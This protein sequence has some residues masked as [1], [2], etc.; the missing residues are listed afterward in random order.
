MRWRSL[1]FPFVLLAA[2]SSVR[3]AE[4]PE[5][6]RVGGIEAYFSGEFD[7]AV[8]HLKH[9][10]S[11]APEAAERASRPDE[12]AAYFLGRSFQELGLRGLALHYLGRAEGAAEW[13]LPALR[14]IARLYLQVAEYPAV[15]EVFARLR[16]GDRDGEI[17][18]LAGIAAAAQG[19]WVEAADI[20]GR[21]GSRDPYH[22]LALY[23]RARARAAA[24]DFTAA[25]GDLDGVA[26]IGAAAPQGLRDQ[27]RILRGKILYLE[28]RPSE[29][30]TAF[31]AV[32]GSGAFGLEALRGLLLTRAGAEAASKKA[33]ST[34]RPADAA[35]LLVVKAVAAEERDDVTGAI[36]LRE[37][38]R[39]ILE[40]RKRRLRELAEGR[41]GLAVLE[42]DLGRFAGLLRRTR[43]TKRWPEE[44]GRLPSPLDHAVDVSPPDGPG[45]FSPRDGTFY[46]VWEQARADPWLRGLIE[47]LSRSQELGE[48]L[49]SASGREPFW[50]FWRRQ[51]D[52]RLA[53]ALLSIRLV[54]LEQL[55]ADHLHTLEAASADELRARKLR[56]LDGT[57]AALERLYLG[58]KPKIPPALS[59]LEKRLDYK[60]YD[61]RR[62]VEAVPERSTD[63]L[64]S[65]L[66]NFVDLL[67]EMR[68]GLVAADV[69]VPEGDAD[70]VALLDALR[71]ANGRLRGDLDGRILRSVTPTFRAQMALFTRLDADNEGSL[72]RLYARTGS[73]EE[74]AR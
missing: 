16:P 17:F 5:E 73:R 26:R 55:L 48:S 40:T 62:L 2:V 61:M 6:A 37:Q 67:E 58:A 3:S 54:N 66:G 70:E 41:A 43:W 22:G 12:P 36:G 29:A 35:T 11:G 34:S 44:H 8:V 42:D 33:V 56:S 49:R 24:G 59:N 53:V 13:R 23:T 18:Y 21:V 46:A 25:L 38:L 47:L 31:A 57:V 68:Q 52:R 4:G 20:L 63:P 64:I 69:A 45:A 19:K 14:E 71:A 74:I 15:L 72:S 50:M 51:Q 32:E 28:E 27:A 10:T 30:R 9:A 39:A 60:E 7:R 1:L 65:L